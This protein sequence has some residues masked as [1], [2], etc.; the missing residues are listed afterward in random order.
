M[1]LT[2][3]AILHYKYGINYDIF[4]EPVTSYAKLAVAALKKQ[5]PMKP[6]YDSTYR[7]N[8]C[9]ACN[10]PFT[11]YGAYRTFHIR[12]AFCGSCGQE[13]DWSGAHEIL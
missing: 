11:F 12:P 3:E 2:E 6:V 9:P 8:Y 10:T 4:A 5:I 1:T 13:L 7:E